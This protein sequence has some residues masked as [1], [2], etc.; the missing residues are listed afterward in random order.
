MTTQ[1]IESKQIVEFRF[2][3]KDDLKNEKWLHW[4]RKYEYPAVLSYISKLK[5]SSIHNTSCGGLNT[6]DCLHLTFCN[7]VIR[8]IYNWK[9]NLSVILLVISK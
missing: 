7:E 6:S 1:T 5:P 4:S 3:R 2:I 9:K 8:R